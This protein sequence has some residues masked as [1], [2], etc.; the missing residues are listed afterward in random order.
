MKK[1]RRLKFRDY[2]LIIFALMNGAQYFLDDDFSNTPVSIEDAANNREKLY[3]LLEK[4]NELE[5]GN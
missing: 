2:L 3:D 1:K 5:N 4:L